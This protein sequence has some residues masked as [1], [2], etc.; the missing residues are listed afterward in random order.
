MEALQKLGID[1]W[2]VLLYLVNIGFLLF[3]L[4]RLLYRPLLKFMDERRATIKNNLHETEQLR[5]RFEEQGKKQAKETKALLAQMQA[6]V[7]AAKAQAEKQAKVLMAEADARRDQ[8]L[9][10]ARRQADET[11]KGILKEAETET[12]KRIEQ[13]ILHVLKN[14]IPTDIVKSSVQAAWKDLYS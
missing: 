11:K 2:S 14:K 9:E 5:A 13:T 6:E 3:V 1:G 7:T 4:T 12:Q 8:I 10:E